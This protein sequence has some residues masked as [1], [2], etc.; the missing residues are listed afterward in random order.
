M[1]IY[2]PAPVT[3]C[4]VLFAIDAIAHPAFDCR[5][6]TVTALVR[7][8][9][10]YAMRW[11]KQRD[12]DD[13][14]ANRFFLTLAELCTEL[15]GSADN[16]WLPRGQSADL[17][18]AMAYTLQHLTENPSLAEIAQAAA[19]S[20]RTL[21][22]RF[23]SETQMNW[24]QFVH[25]ARMIRAAELLAD[26]NTP[27]IEVAYATGFESVSAFTHAFRTWAGETPTK[28]RRRLQPR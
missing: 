9:I 21:A 12:P 8:M 26:P 18:S 22:R 15:A 5:V 4:S 10:A 20:E 2:A 14:V 16:V 25:R 17:Q 6:F 11:G 3:C 7:E 19:I 23:A 27:V 24:R 13:G 1:R 28:F